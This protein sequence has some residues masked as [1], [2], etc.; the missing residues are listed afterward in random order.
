MARVLRGLLVDWGGVLTSTL[1]QAMSTWADT[2]DVD[3]DEYVR[4]MRDWLGEPYA[5]RAIV[6]PVFALERGELEVPHFELELAQRLRTRNGGQVAAEGLL[7]RIFAHFEHAPDMSALVLRARRSG[8]RTGLLSNSW[9]NTYPREGWSEMFDTVVI[10]GEVGMRKPEPRI[11]AL[12]AQRLG[13]E[14]MECVFVDDLRENVDGAVASGMVA[15]LHRSYAD[16]LDKLET[17]FD[18][19]LR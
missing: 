14:P 3:Y 17:L 6:N 12:A 7:D 4:V 13:L 19:P 18:R 5:E 9:G 2:D 1:T 10:S 8:L 11:Y 16:T 15:V